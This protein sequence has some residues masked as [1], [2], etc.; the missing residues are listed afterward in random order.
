MNISRKATKHGGLQRTTVLCPRAF[1]FSQE[2]LD[3]QCVS[4]E[5][6]LQRSAFERERHLLNVLTLPGHITTHSHTECLLSLSLTHY[7]HFIVDKVTRFFIQL[8]WLAQED[9]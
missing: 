6:Y 7:Q 4:S 2:V 5:Y 1:G 9:E 3:D 8:W